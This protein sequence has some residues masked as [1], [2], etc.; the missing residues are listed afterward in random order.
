MTIYQWL[1]TL[2]IP[3]WSPVRPFCGNTQGARLVM[4]FANL[5]VLILW[6]VCRQSSQSF[7]QA[8]IEVDTTFDCLSTLKP[9]GRRNKVSQ[10]TKLLIYKC[11]MYR[12]QYLDIKSL[13][14]LWFVYHAIAM[15]SAPTFTMLVHY[16]RCMEILF[17]KTYELL[18][19]NL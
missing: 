5:T 13:V 4:D 9:M 10:I 8:R 1:E 19:P 6:I 3:T 17:P 12:R 14:K 7:R 18:Q 15:H 16:I 11:Q 2:E